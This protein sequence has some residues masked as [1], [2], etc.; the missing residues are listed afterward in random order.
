[1]FCAS[2]RSMRRSS[3]TVTRLAMSAAGVGI[4]EAST[5]ITSIPASASRRKSVGASPT[6]A[7]AASSHSISDDITVLLMF[8]AGVLASS[9]LAGGLLGQYQLVVARDP[10]AVGLAAE[11]DDD[12]LAAPEQVGCLQRPIR[13]GRMRVLFIR[14]PLH[15]T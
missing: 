13:F 11:F 9:W 14:S 5:V 2:S 6:A 8:V 10:Q 15:L 4:L 3:I 12:L 7:V 1:M